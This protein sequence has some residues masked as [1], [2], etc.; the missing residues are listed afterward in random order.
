MVE[1]LE[2]VRLALGLGKISLLGHSYGGVLALALC[3]KISGKLV[4]PN[5]M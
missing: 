2:A 3:L 1:D 5:L 4:K